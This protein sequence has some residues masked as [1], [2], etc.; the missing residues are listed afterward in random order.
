M[1][2]ENNLSETPL[3]LKDLEEASHKRWVEEVNQEFLKFIYAK[4]ITKIQSRLD[5]AQRH[6]QKADVIKSIDPEM[7]AIRLVAAEEELVVAVFEIIKLTPELAGSWEKITKKFKNHFVKLL[8][9]PA[10]EH[11][12]SIIE[13]FL[14]SEL[15]IEGIEKLKFTSHLTLRD[16]KIILQLLLPDKEPIE[17]SPYL[18]FITTKNEDQIDVLFAD[19]ER[20][21]LDGGYSSIKDFVN[22]RVDFRNKIFYAQDGMIFNVGEDIHGMFPTIV[23]A[24]NDLLA[25][26]C[27]LLSDDDHKENK[28]GIANQLLDLYRSV[29]EKV[30]I[31]DL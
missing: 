28:F 9:W 21:I 16:N 4:K 13:N 19:F 24:I 12:K 14:G 20:K 18:V 7:A 17:T 23:E 11:I 25:I 3:I 27:L 15:Y 5:S 1:G 30:K 6:F 2:A 8:F 26:A 10:A 22:N 31:S 29:L